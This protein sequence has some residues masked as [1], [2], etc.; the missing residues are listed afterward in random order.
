MAETAERGMVDAEVWKLAKA[1]QAILITRDYGFA[2]PVR[3]RTQEVGAVIYL[4][5]A[6]LSSEKEAELVMSFLT[7]HKL[8][9]EYDGRLITLWPGG[10]RIR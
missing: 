1:R 2:N 7:A 5:R 4:R 9:E 3:F 6:N 8:K 10:V